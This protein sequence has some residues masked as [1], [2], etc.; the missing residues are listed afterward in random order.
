MQESF[1]NQLFSIKIGTLI[2]GLLGASIRTLRKS[3]GSLQARITGYLIAI[4]TILYL[5]PFFTWLFTW[6]FGLTLETPAEHLLSFVCGM[7]AQTITENFIDD[8]LGS[9]YQG[10]ATIKKL[11]Q[12]VWNGENFNKSNDSNS[13]LTDAKSED[14]KK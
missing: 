10:S 2:A 7:T 4:F 5:I 8:P 6:K 14:T 9:I 3:E 11:K 1:I 13:I 12:V